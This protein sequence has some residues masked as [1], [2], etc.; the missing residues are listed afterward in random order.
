MEGAARRRL[1]AQAGARANSRRFYLCGARVAL[2][3]LRNTITRNGSKRAR[4]AE[5]S[6]RSPVLHYILLLF[7]DFVALTIY[8][9]LLES[10]PHWLQGQVVLS[11][12]P[13]PACDL[14]NVA[15]PYAALHGALRP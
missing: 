13:D 5:F 4:G 14:K 12:L 11:S 7:Y 9:S 6:P 2:G 3:Q 15:L 8:K 10:V 1:G